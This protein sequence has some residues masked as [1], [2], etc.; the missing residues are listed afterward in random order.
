MTKQ[1]PKSPRAR[2][3]IA[4]DLPEEL[5]EGIVAWG[6]RELTDPGLRPVPG[7]S[8]HVTLAFLGYL[9]EREIESLSRIVAG[10][11]APAPTIELGQPA[12][13]PNLKRA[14]VFAL[15]VDSPDTV[16][17][18]ADLEHKLV[19][20]RLYEPEKRPFWPH[21]TVARVKSEG[22][23]SKRPRQVSKPPGRL[24]KALLQPASCRRLALYRSELRPQ[25]ALY[26]PLAHIDLSR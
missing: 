6:H 8:L 26:T 13:K 5:R 16:A 23:G 17:L 21:I 14:R 4:L 11:G 2:L 1:R 18:Q 15:P 20:E 12:A 25:G 24:P 7:E 19:A 3:F 9:P 22:E 10:I